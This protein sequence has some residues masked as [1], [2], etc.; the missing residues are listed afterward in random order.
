MAGMYHH[1]ELLVEIGSFAQ[2][3][4]KLAIHLISASQE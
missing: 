1:T 4:F 2:A 3:G